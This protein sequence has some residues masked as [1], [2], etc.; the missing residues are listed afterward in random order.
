ME[1]QRVDK[2][3]DRQ[4]DKVIWFTPPKIDPFFTASVQSAV[5][6]SG[7]VY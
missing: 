6:S 1:R 3:I 4:N 7:G 5:L 2:Q